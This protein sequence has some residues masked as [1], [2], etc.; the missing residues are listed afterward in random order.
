M[1]SAVIATHFKHLKELAKNPAISITIYKVDFS[2]L[3]SKQ[4]TTNLK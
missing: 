1:R 2:A 4:T 3:Q